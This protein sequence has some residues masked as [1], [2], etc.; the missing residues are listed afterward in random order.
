MERVAYKSWLDSLSPTD[1]TGCFSS[2]AL[3]SGIVLIHDCAHSLVPA[4]DVRGRSRGQVAD[5]FLDSLKW[6]RPT[7]DFSS[8][9]EWWVADLARPPA[10]PSDASAK[11]ASWSFEMLLGGLASTS[12]DGQRLELAQRSNAFA[13]SIDG[14]W[15]RRQVYDLQHE[16]LHAVPSFW[17]PSYLS[18][19]PL[20]VSQRQWLKSFQLDLAFVYSVEKSRVDALGWMVILR[21]LGALALP[22]VLGVAGEESEE[23]R[24]LRPD[25]DGTTPPACEAHN[26]PRETR[27]GPRHRRNRRS[28]QPQAD[29]P[30]LR[31]LTHCGVSGSRA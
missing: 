4:A 17:P 26:S 27:A 3:L 5:E 31:F 19:D 14:L 12:F 21:L 15:A 16:L 18:A 25:R 6:Q 30:W 8:H 13:A 20:W 9:A 2:S 28:S 29:D 10:D 22:D 23:E 24:F 1:V 11:N 7:L